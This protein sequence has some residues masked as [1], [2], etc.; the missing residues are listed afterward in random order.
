[1]DRVG[2]FFI[3]GAMPLLD[4]VRQHRVIA[5]GIAA[6]DPD[7]VEAALRKILTSL[8]R[9]AGAYPQY[10]ELPAQGRPTPRKEDAP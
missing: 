4:L 2:Y 7:V 6:G 8:P 9:I 1:M 3:E 10:F 5:D